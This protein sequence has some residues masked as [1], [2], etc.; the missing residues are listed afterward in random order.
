MDF[1][2]LSRAGALVSNCLGVSTYVANAKLLRDGAPCQRANRRHDVIDL[3]YTEASRHTAPPSRAGAGLP[4]YRAVDCA[5]LLPFPS[6]IHVDWEH[7]KGGLVNRLLFS[8]TGLTLAAC[9]VIVCIIVL[10]II[11]CACRLLRSRK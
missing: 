9:A 2:I 6:H 10:V 1:F 8:Y 4:S 11:R 3:L 7:A 5:A